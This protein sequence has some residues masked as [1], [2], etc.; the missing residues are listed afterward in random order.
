MMD[1]DNPP[2]LNTVDLVVTVLMTFFWL[3]AAS[4]LAW[5][6]GQLINFTVQESFVHEHG[7]AN[8][9]KEAESKCYTELAEFNKLTSSVA[10]GFL[11]LFLW[12]P[13]SKSF[14]IKINQGYRT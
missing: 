9:C 13:D 4:S 7:L 5:A 6:K 8:F 11:N 10:F 3:C 2:T 1:G 12:M 14:A